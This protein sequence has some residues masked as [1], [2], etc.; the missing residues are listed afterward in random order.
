MAK[1]IAVC[2]Q[3][4]ASEKPL[5]PSISARILPLRESGFFSLILTR[6]QTPVRHGIN[7]PALDK[8]VYHGVIGQ[9]A[10]ENLI[11]RT[12]V[13]DYHVIPASADL[14]GLLVELVPLPQREYFCAVS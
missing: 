9:T 7:V 1:I 12:A 3:K 11:K 10:P 2:N 13:N 5:P 6:R 8:S 4:G 14:A